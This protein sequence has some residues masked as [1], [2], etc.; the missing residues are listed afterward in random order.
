MLC[1]MLILSIWVW[2]TQGQGENMHPAKIYANNNFKEG[3]RLTI[4]CSLFGLKEQSGKAYFYLCK[5]GQ[6]MLIQESTCLDVM[7]HIDSITKNYSGHYSCVYSE[8]KYNAKDVKGHSA[9]VLITVDDSSVPAN[10]SWPKASMMEGGDVELRCTSSLVLDSW[11]DMRNIYAYLCKNGTVIQVNIWDTEKKEAIFTLKKVKMHD[12]GTYIC[13]LSSDIWPIPDMMQGNN[14]AHLHVIEGSSDTIR[15]VLVTSALLP[16]LILF[17]GIWAVIKGQ[18]CYRC[19]I[20]RSLQP[21]SESRGFDIQ[22]EEE[23]SPTDEVQNVPS[24]NSCL[25]WEDSSDSYDE[26]CNLQDVVYQV[27]E[28]P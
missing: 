6:V 27:C 14:E 25:E 24:L 22:H 17:L 26:T 16:C 19:T 5:D 15:I 23:L 2:I 12:A 8:Q 1:F 3:G 11:Q 4:K 10:I 20:E 13:F 7:F 9:N 21:G 18:V 28:D